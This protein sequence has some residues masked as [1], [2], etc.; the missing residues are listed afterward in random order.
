MLTDT[1]GDTRRAD[2]GVVH[3][4][5]HRA[6]AAAARSNRQ[7]TKVAFV[8]GEDDE[9]LR[10]Y[11]MN[12]LA[13]AL[14][15]PCYE[16]T[17][18]AGG[19]YGIPVV[20]AGRH[21]ARVR[22]RRRGQGREHPGLRRRLHDDGRH[23][24]R[25]GDAGPIGR[26]GGRQPS[27]TGA[28]AD[29]PPSRPD[30]EGRRQRRRRPVGRRRRRAGATGADRRDAPASPSRARSCAPPCATD[31]SSRIA[32]AKPGKLRV[33]ARAGK[34]RVATGTATV[35]SDG[36]AH[37]PPA[38]HRS[39]A[40]KPGLKADREAHDRRTG[41]P[42]RRHDAQALTASRQ[43]HRHRARAHHP[44]ADRRRW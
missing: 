35:R 5:R 10:V 31:S 38:L 30:H 14:P 11:T 13:A 29:V 2:Q 32:G 33:D 18:P 40:P 19:H 27:P 9:Q 4:Q 42:Q 23:G 1:I 26:P 43:P 37:R 12:A 20:V 3:R 16:Y 25:R 34:R 36:T 44:G 7:G 17:G 8:A 41:H 24:R 6:P 28:R 15:T 22:R 21:P 39:G